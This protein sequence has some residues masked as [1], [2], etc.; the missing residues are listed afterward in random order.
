MHSQGDVGAPRNSTSTDRP[1]NLA[2]L[3]AV[4][5]RLD[6]RL[7]RLEA[8]L[9]RTE[10]LA[11]SIAPT[12]ATV[13]DT[14][15]SLVARLGDQGIDVDERLHH[16]LSVAERLTRQDTLRAVGTMLD[17]GVLDSDAVHVLGNLGRALAASGTATPERVGM[18]GLIRALRDPEV[19][20]AAGFLVAMARAFGASLPVPAA[21]PSGD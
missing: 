10:P 19:Q 18:F 3:A 2:D 9:D 8:A 6:R 17:S 7:A 5:E 1:A 14:L 12:V 15:D 21:L 11:G 13:V 20:R 4:L 16:L